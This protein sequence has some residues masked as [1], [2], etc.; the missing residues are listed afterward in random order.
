MANQFEDDD[1]CMP[2]RCLMP[3]VHFSYECHDVA[4]L[5]AP[6]HDLGCMEEGPRETCDYCRDRPNG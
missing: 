1:C 5:E 4:M 6:Q 3:G 2:D